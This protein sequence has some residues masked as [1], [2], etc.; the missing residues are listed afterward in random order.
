ML[1]HWYE[2]G[3]A[4]V[5]P[6]RVAMDSYRLFFNHPFNP[7]MYT[8]LGR[9]AAAACEVFE[10]TTRRYPKPEFGIHTTTFEEKSVHVS[11]E[12]VW[13]TPFCRLLHFKRDIAEHKSK[14]QPRILLVAPMS[15]HFATLLRGT[16]ETLLPQHEVYIT[17]WIDAR[18]IPPSAGLFDLDSYIDHVIS[19]LRFLNGDVHVFAVCQPSVPV[20]AAV[21]R[22][23]ATNDP[24]RPQSMIL[25]GGPIDT[26]I[27]PTAI[28]KVAETRGTEWFR[29]NVL[30]T[31]PW[32]FAGFG[33]SVYP[34]FMQLTGF[35]AMNLNRHVNAHQE[36]FL[37]LVRGD[38]DSAEKHRVFYDEYLAVMDLTAEF[39]MQTIEKVFVQHALPKGEMTHHDQ[40]VD[41]QAIKRVPMMT[42]EGEKD[43]ITGLGQCR[44]AHGLTPNLPVELKMHFEFDGVGHYGIF[45]GSRF[46]ADIAPRI[47]Q[48]V[49]MHDARSENIAT[50]T[51]ATSNAG[52]GANLSTENKV[53][54]FMPP[55]S[56]QQIPDEQDTPTQEGATVHNSAFAK[57]RKRGF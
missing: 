8:S 55:Q 25:A 2:L 47:T 53:V 35:M 14:D 23:E 45:N 50:S 16:V 7:L 49:Y 17:D 44:A 42:I 43:D 28:N 1:Y 12:T 22:M 33:R 38:G 4:A 34:G 10:R 39:Y 32:P 46:R 36:L 30:A 15:G 41:L 9:T 57:R 51:P 52:P 6:A 27:N 19:M 48:F 40:P 31:V 3:H 37:N 5:K 56:Q 26:R 20:L 54:N 21:A 24:K 11:Q 18:S 13:E 29:N